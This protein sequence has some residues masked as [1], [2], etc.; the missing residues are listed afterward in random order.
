MRAGG[1]AIFFW[2]GGTEVDTVAVAEFP[3]HVCRHPLMVGPKGATLKR[4]SAETAVRVAVP[5]ERDAAAA[6][7]QQQGW[8]PSALV[9]KNLVIQVQSSLG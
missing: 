5:S 7:Q 2:G 3:L 6:A 8:S 1:R 9:D 4:I